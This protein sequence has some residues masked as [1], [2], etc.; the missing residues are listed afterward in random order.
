MRNNIFKFEIQIGNYFQCWEKSPIPSFLIALVP[1]SLPSFLTKLFTSTLIKL[2]PSVFDQ[3]ARYKSLNNVSF[4][5]VSM[6]LRPPSKTQLPM[7]IPKM[8]LTNFRHQ[9]NI[10]AYVMN[11]K[12]SNRN[13]VINVPLFHYRRIRVAIT[14][15][16]VPMIC[17]HSYFN[18]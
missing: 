16:W 18:R 17:R 9:W 14:K 7:K 3:L 4:R 6:G 15:L 2:I 10:W 13:D 12:S 8:R 1:H 5:T 11:L